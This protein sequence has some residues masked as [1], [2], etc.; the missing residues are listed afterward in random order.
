MNQIDVDIL[1]IDKGFTNSYIL[2]SES[3]IMIDVPYNVK[4]F[5][6]KM[7]EVPI[8]VDEVELIIITHGHLDH[9]A[10]LKEIK[11]V[12][13]A[14][15]AV[16]KNDI[17]GLEGSTIPVPTG[18]TAWGSVTRV[19]LNNLVSPFLKAPLIETDLVL[20][21]EGLSLSEYGIPGRIYHT[22]GHTE[23][24]C[25]VLLDNGKAF[26]GDIAMNKFPLCLSPRLSIYSHDYRK[27]VDSWRI[28]LSRG[29]EKIYPGHGNPFPVG[30][31]RESIYKNDTTSRTDA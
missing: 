23:G 21:D 28:L 18:V 31:I 1:P 19:I 16:H 14:K 5:Y 7:E 22:P 4:D 13:S 10:S 3:S 2:H 27:L 8:E 17:R 29:A 11:E 20:G 6:K 12:T 15:V 9:F 24:S 25:S 30:I 26:V